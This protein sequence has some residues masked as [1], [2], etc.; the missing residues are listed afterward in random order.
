M[1][2]QYFYFACNRCLHTV[3]TIVDNPDIHTKCSNCGFE[4]F[5]ELTKKEYDQARLERALAR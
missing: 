2:P 5:H 3:R 4:Y 1:T